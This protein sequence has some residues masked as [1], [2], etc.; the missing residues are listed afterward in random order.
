MHRGIETTL[1]YVR[2]NYWI[3]RGRTTVK[4]I[5]RKCVTCTRYQGVAAKPPPSPDFSDYRVDYL[6]HAFQATGLDFARPLLVK[7]GSKKTKACILLL[8]CASSRA[9]HLEFVPDMSV[10]GFLRGFKRFMAG[11]SVPDVVNDNFKTFK[12]VEVK[13]FMVSYGITQRF[14]LPASPWWGG[15]Y[16][17]LVRSVKMCLKKVLGRVFVTL[18][19]LHTILCEIEAV[20][21]SRPLACACED[22]LNEVLTPFHML[23]GR[24][25]SESLK[26]TDSVISTGLEPCK[27]RLLH[28]RKVLKDYWSRFRDTYLNELRQMNIYRKDKHGKGA[29]ITVGDVVLI[30]DDE[31]VPRCKWRLGKISQ[32]VVGRD[33][34]VRGAKLK[35]ISKGGQ[36]TTMF[37]PI[38]KQVPFEIVEVST[39][40]ESPEVNENSVDKDEGD[41]EIGR[42]PGKAAV[43]GQN[44]R[45]LHEQFN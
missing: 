39:D 22:D 12:A 19:E 35:A 28:V 3:V 41:R 5:L 11:K 1:A 13:R 26:L 40:T 36:Q 29:D 43:E 10:S 4:D 23:H 7:E 42:R 27:R 9:I 8:T 16:E 18:E 32:L 14:I 44:L 17:R 15:F 34:Q 2:R 25:I 21:N 33:T 30:K 6:T 20:I 24:D 31:P 37:R 38:Q 45:R